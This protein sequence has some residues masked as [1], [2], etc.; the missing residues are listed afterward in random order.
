MS[1][2]CRFEEEPL[3]GYFWDVSCEVGKLGCTADQKSLQ[4]RFCG[5]GDYASIPCPPSS[6]HFPNEPS[7]PYFWDM[8]CEMGKL[9]CWADGVHEQCRFCGRHP[10]TSVDCPNDVTV[11]LAT[12]CDFDHEPA[13]PYFFDETCREGMLGCL[14]DGKSPGCRFCGWGVYSEIECPPEGTAKNCTFANQPGVPFYWENNC[15]PGVLGCLA[16]GIHPQ[17]R[18]CAVRPFESIDCP[19]DVAP[20]FGNCSFPNEP[21]TPYFWDETCKMGM[22]GCW[23]DGLHAQCRF[24]GEG[25]YSSV[26]CGDV[27]HSSRNLSSVEGGGGFLISK[28][29]GSAVAR[30]IEWSAITSKDEELSHGRRAADAH[31]AMGAVVGVLVPSLM[32]LA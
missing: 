12:A 9:G 25:V 19:G 27:K 15:A 17:C 30:D 29:S 26:A 3:T 22:L 16:D 2:E 23:A 20:P 21:V 31:L 18:F 28:P 5:G 32:S 8:S 13:T 24:C 4:C 10:F 11:P 7:I 14:A 6:C 1:G